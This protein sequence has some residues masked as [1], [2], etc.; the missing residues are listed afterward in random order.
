MFRQKEK[1]WIRVLMEDVVL[2][3]NRKTQKTKVKFTRR[4][5]E[6]AMGVE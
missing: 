6:I 5:I 3:L 4:K 1:I 2:L